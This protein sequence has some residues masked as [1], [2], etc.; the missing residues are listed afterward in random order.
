ME[1]VTRVSAEKTLSP[2]R[3]VGLASVTAPNSRGMG[4]SSSTT[5]RVDRAGMRTWRESSNSG[6]TVDEEKDDADN[7]DWE[8]DEDDDD[9]DDEEEEDDEEDW[10]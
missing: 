5:R 6:S 9:D 8:D 7:E 1:N 3:T 10:D 4:S 2:M